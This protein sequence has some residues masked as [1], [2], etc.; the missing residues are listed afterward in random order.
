MFNDIFDIIYINNNNNN[1]N[2]SNLTYSFF[3]FFSKDNY[4]IKNKFVFY[5]TTNSNIFLGKK[6][7]KEFNDL[8]YRVQFVYFA[9]TKFVNN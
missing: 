6:E 8:F 3:N 2:V 1:N 5:E 9:L 7:K 4:S